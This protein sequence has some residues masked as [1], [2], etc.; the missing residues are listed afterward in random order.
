MAL[1]SV[2]VPVYNVEAYLHRCVDSILGQTFRDF[3]LILVDDGSPDNCGRI[4]D[5][6][7]KSDS[8]IRVIHQKNGGLSAARNTGIDWVFANSDSQWLTFV[9]SDDWIHR[10][11]LEVLLKMAQ[12]SQTKLAMCSLVLIS[13]LCEDETIHNCQTKVMEAETAYI[14]HYSMCMTAN[15]KLY[16]RELWETMRF[17]V[18]KLHEDA[19]VT[20]IL[21]FGAGKVCLC[22]TALYYYYCNNE[23]ITRARWSP[24]RLDEIQAHEERLAFFM[25]LGLQECYV[26]QVSAYIETLCVQ[27][28]QIQNS[29]SEEHLKFGR[30]LRK[31]LRAALQKARSYGVHLF[32]EAYWGEY[33]L[34]Y[35]CRMLRWVLYGW[36]KIMGRQK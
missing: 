32:N 9:D 10:D 18:G 28:E 12:E 8:R 31:K 4:C 23:S 3:E 24:K 17:P 29:G 1:I 22:E 36:L 35:P 6:Y 34:A 26:K 13:E 14:G 19:F 7:A 11:Y 25:E 5:E 27:I 21:L 15:C 2:I 20:H 30:Q 33:T 16:C